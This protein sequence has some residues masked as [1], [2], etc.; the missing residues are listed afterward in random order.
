M[1]RI[2]ILSDVHANLP[3]LK[4]VLKDIDDRKVDQVFC[5][6]DLVDFAPWPNEVIE[7]IRQYRIP[8]LMGNHDERIAFDHPVVSLAKHNLAETEARV[9]AIDYTRRAIRQENKDFLASLP[10]Q[11]QLSFSFADLAINV[12]L[13]HAS[14][15]SI[16]EYIYETHDQADLEAMMNEKKAD[17]LLMGH[18]HQSYI[19]VLPVSSDKRP[20]KVAINCGSVGRSKEANPFATYLIMTVSGEHLAFGSDSLMFD[21]INVNYPIQQTIEGIYSSP[22]P[23][24]YADF[25]EKKLQK[26][27][28]YA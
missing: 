11:I 12:L 23:D 16:D 2:A 7:L 6:G 15:R 14:T 21:L 26:F 13:V 24:F 1:L 18:T 3:A 9:K 17:V 25:L 22:I 5:L 27:P 8:T 10:R 28:S 4:A 19:R 20:A